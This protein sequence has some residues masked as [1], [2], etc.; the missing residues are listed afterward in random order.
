MFE[1]DPYV[2]AIALK[3]ANFRCQ[4]PVCNSEP[5]VTTSGKPYSEVHHL[6]PL[7]EGGEDSP[8]NAVC[9]CPNHHRE[10]HVGV[11]CKEITAV[12]TAV[13]RLHE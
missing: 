10:L 12:L 3:R 6:V 9:V 5:F 11:R 4:V 8:E 2:R 13:L 7:A 1:R